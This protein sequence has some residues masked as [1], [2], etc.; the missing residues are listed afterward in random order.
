MG[1]LDSIREALGL[2]ASTDATREADPDDLF[3]LSGASV[4]MEA[5]LDLEPI[6][7][8]GIGFSAMGST[9]FRDAVRDVEAV[10]DGDGWASVHED[11]HG[12][13]WAVAEREDFESLVTDLYVAADTLADRG[14]SD[15]LLAAVF[16]FEPIVGEGRAYWIYSFRRGS[17]Y[18][19]APRSMRERDS[20]L[21]VKL[22][23]VLDDEMDVE[24][25]TGYWYPL[26]PDR[27]G[28]H[29]WE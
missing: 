28:G 9:D 22:Q 6:S 3:Q 11:E 21:E 8:A 15:R 4:T 17:F 27:N 29:P 10:L 12:Y 19:F 24:E 18:P 23:S 5:D 13:T 25:D 26:W 1:V 20:A 16:G 14:Y 2:R 7:V